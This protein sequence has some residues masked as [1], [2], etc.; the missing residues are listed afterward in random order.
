MPKFVIEMNYSTGSWARMLTVTD[1]RAA[2]VAALCEHL[3]GKLNEMFW[4]VENASAYVIADLPDSVSA[5]AA[6]TAATRT[7]AFREVKV[8]EVLTQDQLR[9]VVALARTSKDVYRPPGTAAIDAAD[10]DW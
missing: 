7:G 5:A 6:V 8:H 10:D 9:E 4:E 3:H 2:A 1:D